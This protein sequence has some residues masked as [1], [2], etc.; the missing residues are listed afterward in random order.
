MFLVKEEM[1]GLFV[2]VFVEVVELV[3]GIE[4][5]VVVGDEFCVFGDEDFVWWVEIEFGGF[6]VEEFVVNVGLDE[7]VVGV[8]V[9]FG[10][11]EFGGGEVF[12]YVY[13]YGIF[14]C[15]VGGIDVGDFVLRDGRGVVYDEWEVGDEIF[16]FLE[17]VEV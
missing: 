17:D 11:V 4:E 5:L 7:V 8:D 9:D 15:V 10:D 1:N 13:V 6:V 14:D 3:G 12:V 2:E 16:D